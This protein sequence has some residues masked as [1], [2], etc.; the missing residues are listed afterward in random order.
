[1]EGSVNKSIKAKVDM[2]HATNMK[3][4]KRKNM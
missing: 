4:K 1:M 2:R 3:K